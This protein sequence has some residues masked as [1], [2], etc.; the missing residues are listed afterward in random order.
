[1]IFRRLALA[2]LLAPVAAGPAWPQS[3]CQGMIEAFKPI[4]E[5]TVKF[6]QPIITT[7]AGPDGSNKKLCPM[8]RQYLPVLKQEIDFRKRAESMG[9]NLEG[10]SAAKLDETLEH[11]TRYVNSQW[12][13]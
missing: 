3:D 9:C 11:H 8:F 7:A 12:C 4:R 6:L 1:M 13:Q 10:L 5:Q 2:V